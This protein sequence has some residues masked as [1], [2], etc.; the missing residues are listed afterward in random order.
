MTAPTARS[1][2][3]RWSLPKAPPRASGL[4]LSPLPLTGAAAAVLRKA[5]GHLTNLDNPNGVEIAFDS[6]GHHAPW[7]TMLGSPPVLHDLGAGCGLVVGAAGEALAFRDLRA[8]SMGRHCVLV[9]VPLR[10]TGP[11]TPATLAWVAHAPAHASFI[12]KG[13]F[14]LWG[15]VM[16][17]ETSDE[18]RTVH[19]IAG[20][21]AAGQDLFGVEDVALQ[22]VRHPSAAGWSNTQPGRL[23][24]ERGR[25]PPTPR[26]SAFQSLMAWAARDHID[27]LPVRQY[28]YAGT[29]RHNGFVADVAPPRTTSAH[30][31]AE[32]LHTWMGHLRHAQQ[33]WAK[34]FPEFNSLLEP[35]A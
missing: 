29:A 26:A 19:A 17:A 11:T 4:V 14:P 5:W 22:G 18:D 23:E 27:G 7:G 30:A 3:K 9:P 35:T 21:V 1:L 13:V 2:P 31:R 24:W 33:G 12:G 8:A 25:N 32:R 6:P 20:M 16:P 10:L 15:G 28:S 34:V